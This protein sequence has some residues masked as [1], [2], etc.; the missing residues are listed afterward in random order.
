MRETWILSLGWEDP[1]EKVITPVFW[2]GEFHGLYSL[3]GCK[4]SD[5][6]ERLSVLLSL[7]QCLMFRH[8]KSPCYHY[9]YFHYLSINNMHI[10][11][12]FI[13]F[14]FFIFLP[15]HRACGILVP[16]PGIKPMSPSLGTWSL[17]HWTTRDK[18]GKSFSW[19]SWLA[20]IS[21]KISGIVNQWH[22]W[23]DR[24]FSLTR[25]VTS[26]VDTWYPLFPAVLY[27]CWCHLRIQTLP[28]E[29]WKLMSM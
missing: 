18:W 11:F 3:W 1:L 9:Q 28:S 17:N 6:T 12:Y 24:P 26:P 22:G 10:L 2:P 14:Y 16:W 13:Y 4:K 21:W 19:Q 23:L 7:T 25:V 8:H 27:S 29:S 15:L 5:T 20:L